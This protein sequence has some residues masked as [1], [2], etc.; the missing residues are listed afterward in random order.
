MLELYIEQGAFNSL[1]LSVKKAGRRLSA[2][3]SEIPAAIRSVLRTPQ[4]YG[5]M[6]DTLISIFER[7][8]W[9][10]D[11]IVKLPTVVGK[12]RWTGQEVTRRILAH[13]T[14][15]SVEFEYR[16]YCSDECITNEV[17]LGK[18]LVIDKDTRKIY[19]LGTSK[20]DTLWQKILEHGG[21]SDNEN[22]CKIPISEWTKRYSFLMDDIS[23]GISENTI[24][25]FPNP[26]RE[27]S[28]TDIQYTINFSPEFSK[29]DWHY[30]LTASVHDHQ[31][32]A[33]QQLA[34]LI[35]LDNLPNNQEFDS[36]TIQK[37]HRYQRKIAK[38]ILDGQP[39]EEML[40]ENQAQLIDSIITP[41]TNL[42]TRPYYYV[43]PDVDKWVVIQANLAKEAHTLLSL[44]PSR[45]LSLSELHQ[46]AQGQKNLQDTLSEAL[47]ELSQKNTRVHINKKEMEIVK[48]DVALNVEKKEDWFEIHPRIMANNNRVSQEDILEQLAHSGVVEKDGKTY[49]LDDKDLKVLQM[50]WQEFPSKPGEKKSLPTSIPV[51]R[52]HLI[53][54]LQFQAMGVNLTLPPEEEALL[55]KL[56]NFSE[57]EPVP[58]PDRLGKI[59][60][61][62]Q[63]TGYQWLAFL[64][65]HQLGGILADDMGLGKTI[66]TLSLIQAIHDGIIT[67]NKKTPC[68]CLIVMP[69]SLKF[70]WV[71]EIERFCPDLKI[72]EFSTDN[73][74]RAEL[75]N[76]LIISY[77]M[78]RRNIDQ[79]KSITFKVVVLD[80]A[81]MIKNIN[82]ERGKAIRQL[83]GEFKLC[84]TGTP[85]ENHLGEFY[86]IMDFVMPGIFD[87]YSQFQSAVKKSQETRL[88][89][90]A[91]P[92]VMRRKK[93]S[94]LTE[95]PPKSESDI[96]LD[97]SDDQK[98]LYAKI[99][100]EVKQSIDDAYRDRRS[101]QAPFMALTGLL[102]LRQVCIS[103]QL[104][105]ETKTKPSPKIEYILDK[106]N[107]LQDE[108]HSVLIF[109][110]FRS[111]LNILGDHLK[112]NDISFCQL[113][114]KT[115]VVKRKKI[116]DQFQASTSPEV[117]LISLKAGGVGLN[118][119]KASYVL[120]VDPWWNPAVEDQAAGRSHR[121]GQTQ[122][123]FIVRL[124][125]RH[126]IEEKMMAL[127][128]RKK[129][130]F[131]SI[132]SLSQAGEKHVLTKDDF[133]YLL[134]GWDQTV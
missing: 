7:K 131:D 49:V 74:Q 65:S 87:S 124:L 12:C 105:D 57:I 111:F 40:A 52:H 8:E 16:A 134:S 51:K 80:E 92:F 39:A 58:V 91:L 24:R 41:F 10:G 54:W 98:Q 85:M 42:L 132:E 34:R 22:T 71:R 72:A 47:I 27:F 66:Q 35:W 19:F 99:I 11:V 38:A 13:L 20:A 96:F 117:F 36:Q 68:H 95:L 81:Q 62:Y 97:A 130:L 67:N 61:H 107:E 116:I 78:V 59:L 119:T 103:P 90:R 6:E 121:I 9:S 84:L 102:R 123:V 1:R 127:K 88:I 17:S 46:I 15:D 122:K 5:S 53:D 2:N 64:F 55:K 129:A 79:L 128:E 75:P 23:N 106:I 31:V 100:A 82:S 30:E 63:I 77:E 94:I 112:K 126:T 25:F 76:I 45:Q 26:S 89:K 14:T 32:P 118:L 37:I 115:P 21:V 113:D 109:S 125:M 3:N 101:G 73:F 28:E 50:L 86:S 60:R 108:G 120:L 44:I 33:V 4:A 70:N 43:F 69:P 48:W 83:N 29:K 18:G 110:Q 133:D 56:F 114:G 93:E 104:V